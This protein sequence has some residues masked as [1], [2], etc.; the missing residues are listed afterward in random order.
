MPIEVADAAGIHPLA[1]T[2]VFLDD[3]YAFGVYKTICVQDCDVRNQMKGNNF[4]YR[5][6]PYTSST[7]RGLFGENGGS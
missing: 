4:S 3:V 7:A 1:Q 5:R 2:N 6:P